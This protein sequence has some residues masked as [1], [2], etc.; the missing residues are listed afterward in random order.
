MRIAVGP[1]LALCLVGDVAAHAQQQQS[2]AALPELSPAVALAFEDLSPRFATETEQISGWFRDRPVQYYNFGMVAQPVVVGRVVWPI[3][4]FD[5]RGNPVAVRGQRPI[6]SAIP[7]LET[8]SG[9]WRLEYL[10]TADLAQPNEIRTMAGVDAFVRRRRATVRAT[11]LVLNLPIVARGTRLPQDSTAGAIGWFEGREVQFFDFGAVSV[12][13]APMWRFARGTTESGEPMLVEGQGGLLDSIPVAPTY[14]DLWDIRIVRVDSTYAANAIRSALALRRA[15]FPI[16]SARF[17][18]NL[19]VT[20]VDGV[21]V[22]RAVSPITEFADTR[23]PFP[24]A[25]TKM[26]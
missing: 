13:P 26:P 16:D 1:L 21:R 23:S 22:T 7:G 6:F 9:L 12:A 19:P 3:H 17:V 14:P 20:I 8:Y 5:A 25:P 11:D 10:V 24:P 4:G 18:A 2:T 15:S